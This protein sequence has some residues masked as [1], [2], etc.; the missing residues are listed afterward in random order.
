MQKLLGF[1]L[2]IPE[3]RNRNHISKNSSSNFSSAFYD[4]SE[5]FS[6]KETSLQLQSPLQMKG[7][8]MSDSLCQSPVGLFSLWNVIAPWDTP[9]TLHHLGTSQEQRVASAEQTACRPCCLTTILPTV[10]SAGY[11]DSMGKAVTKTSLRL[12]NTSSTARRTGHGEIMLSHINCNH[13]SKQKC[14]L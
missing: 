8:P 9:L 3:A 1:D 13:Q 4:F 7:F 2:T 11:H 14:I 12:Q 6:E 10:L 5:G